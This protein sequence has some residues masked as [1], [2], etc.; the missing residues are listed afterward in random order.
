LGCGLEKAD[1]GKLGSIDVRLRAL[2]DPSI[3][4][5][6]R[7]TERTIALLSMANLASKRREG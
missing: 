4:P 1:L 7:A 6:S 3:W 2:R 5:P